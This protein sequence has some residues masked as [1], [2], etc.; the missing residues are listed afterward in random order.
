MSRSSGCRFSVVHMGEKV[1]G[2][3]GNGEKGGR[4][5]SGK[6]RCEELRV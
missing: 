3:V 1:E 4:K 2:L 6:P 5:G